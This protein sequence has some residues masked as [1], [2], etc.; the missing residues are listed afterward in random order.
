MDGGCTCGEIRYR[1]TEAPLFTHCCHCTWCQRETGAAFAMNAMIET[2]RL[3]LLSGV[4]DYVTIPSQSGHGQHIARCPTC[5]IAVWSYYGRLGRKMACVR[6][7][8]L[9]EPGKCPPGA[10]IFTSTKQPWL[11]LSDHLPAFEAFYNRQEMWPAASLARYA[12]LTA[13]S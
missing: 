11:A 2:D 8:T 12:V 4:P 10:H 5:R 6:V 13:A 1:L 7:G 9:D 3:H